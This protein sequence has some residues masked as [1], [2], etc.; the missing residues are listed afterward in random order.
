MPDP[1][2][3]QRITLRGRAEPIFSGWRVDAELYVEVYIAAEEYPIS[4]E[5]DILEV[6]EP[7]DSQQGGQPEP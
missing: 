4:G 3:S 2:V 7:A 5:L 6:L 1:A